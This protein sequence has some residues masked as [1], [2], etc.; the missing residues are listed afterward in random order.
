MPGNV[1]AVFRRQKVMEAF[2]CELFR[3]LCGESWAR[4]EEEATSGGRDAGVLDALSSAISR[5]PT[6]SGAGAVLLREAKTMAL[7][8][9]SHRVDHLSSVAMEYR[10][11]PEGFRRTTTI[12]TGTAGVVT[13]R[14]LVELA[15][16]LASDPGGAGQWAGPELRSGLNHLMD[17]PSL[18]RAA[19]FAVIATDMH[20]R[21]GSLSGDI[22]AGW[23]WA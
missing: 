1:I 3:I 4:A 14:W 11:L 16:R 9:C 17:S 7:Q 5:S 8:D 15:L 6:E 18:P 19:R 2:T 13:A 22:Y 23:R 12:Q 21:P 20:V 10:L